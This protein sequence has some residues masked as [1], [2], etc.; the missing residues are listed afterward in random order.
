M[1]QNVRGVAICPWTASH[2]EIGRPGFWSPWKLRFNGGDTQRPYAQARIIAHQAI[3]INAEFSTK[4]P[5]KIT[6]WSVTYNK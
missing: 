5:L 2:D 3:K 6:L 4:V 1:S